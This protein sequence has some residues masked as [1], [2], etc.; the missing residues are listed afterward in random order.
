MKDLTKWFMKYAGAVYARCH[1]DELFVLVPTT[2]VS[3]GTY[4]SHS[5]NGRPLKLST[6]YSGEFSV[7]CTDALRA[8]AQTSGVKLPTFSDDPKNMQSFSADCRMGQWPSLKGALA[9]LGGW[10]AQDCQVNGLSDAVYQ[11]RGK[12]GKVDV[13]SWKTGKLME[14]SSGTKAEWLQQVCELPL[15]ESQMYGFTFRTVFVMRQGVNPKTGQL[16]PPKSKPEVEYTTQSF[17][18]LLL[19]DYFALAGLSPVCDNPGNAQ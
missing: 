5:Y 4:S 8:F 2:T 3:Q 14:Q 7:R 9:L 16:A 18:E 6:L 12:F 19:S 13:P 15:P 10:R 11:R 17:F 1:S